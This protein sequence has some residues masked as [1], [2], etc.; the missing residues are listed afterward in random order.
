M[1]GGGGGCR[2]KDEIID[3]DD[4]TFGRRPFHCSY[5]FYLMIIHHPLYKAVT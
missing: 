2:R 1:F 5:S 4:N 3:E